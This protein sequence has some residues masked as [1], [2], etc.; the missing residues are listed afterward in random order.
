MSKY[1]AY[2]SPQFK[3][4]ADH[5]LDEFI[6]NESSCATENANDQT[7]HPKYD[8]LH[9]NEMKG[10]PDFKRYA[11]RNFEKLQLINPNKIPDCSVTTD[12]FARAKELTLRSSPKPN[13]F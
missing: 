5:S 3:N 8:L 7:Y 11:E 4:W 9:R 1:K 6:K 12:G 10:V 13:P 2:N